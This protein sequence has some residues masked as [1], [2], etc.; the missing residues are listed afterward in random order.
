[1]PTV[2]TVPTVPPLPTELWE[3]IAVSCGPNEL[4]S[5][6]GVCVDTK[7]AVYDAL[8]SPTPPSV[9]CDEDG[10]SMFCNREQV[11]A[12]VRVVLLGKSLFLTGGAGSGKSFV[13]RKIVSYVIDLVSTEQVLVVAPTGPAAR[14]ASTPNKLAQTIHFAFNISN[15]ARS[16]T[17]PPFKKSLVGYGCKEIEI[18]EH[19]TVMNNDAPS[20]NEQ[21][22]LP[23]SRLTP[24]T[25]HIL[26]SLK[27]LVI[28]EISMVSNE[29]FTLMDLTLRH[30]RGS[31]KPFGGVVLLCVGDFCQLPPVVTSAQAVARNKRLGGGIWAFQSRS[32]FMEG[33]ALRQIV[34]QKDPTFAAVLNR[35]R[36][37]KASWSDASWLNRLTYRPTS[38]KL[39]IFPSNDQCRD[40]NMV[41]MNKLVDGGA[42]T[43]TFQRKR[44]LFLLVK[45]KPWQ[46]Q[47]VPMLLPPNENTWPRTSFPEA[48]DITVCVGARVRATKNIYKSSP[49]A[50]NG[51]GVYIEV[52]NGQR[53]TVTSVSPGL[54]VHVQWDPL[55]PNEESIETSVSSSRRYKKQT[56]KLEN[57]HVYA[58]STFLPLSLAWAITVHSSQGSSVDM[59]VDVNHRVM[60][61]QGEDWTPQAGGA[62]VALSRATKIENLKILRRFHPNDAVLCKSVRKFLVANGLLE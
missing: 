55:H 23:T 4:A 33:L 29:F 13:T 6:L 30:V 62:Y 46:L 36:V 38:P 9:I 60:T 39:S 22:K 11:E 8:T 3:Q 19:D 37:G 42:E 51:S 7:E 10:K 20:S 58:S 44:H 24:A 12:F 35:I 40:R 57:K 27:F 32:W 47:P 56:Y 34:R 49:N 2:P 61:K 41:E 43:Y 16:E 18:E 5:L 25:V 50:T 26:A 48:N 14:L 52:A 1:M 15:I 31:D 53:G 21:S 45:E 28:D 54:S 17:D 59:P